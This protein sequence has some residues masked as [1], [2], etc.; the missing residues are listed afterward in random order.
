MNAAV[1]VRS[2]TTVGQLR[3]AKARFDAAQAEVDRVLAAKPTPPD[4][5][6]VSAAL[7]DARRDF[8]DASAARALGTATEAELRNA[9]AA[10][11][12]ARKAH[13]AAAVKAEQFAMLE[14]GFARALAQAQAEVDAAAEARRE[15][16][17]EWLRAE[18]VAT[19]RAY[20]E[21]ADRLY[22]AWRRA[23]AIT[24]ASKARRG[25]WN[26]YTAMAAPPTIAP[27]GVWRDVKTHQGEMYR[28]QRID[29]RNGVET[30]LQLASMSSPEA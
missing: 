18:L 28:A 12:K 20:C 14:A 4:P 22:A 6:V 26:G 15:A 21:A 24:N 11:E 8:E 3:A 19:D 23:K 17:V 7:E 30:A 16:E 29:D 2:E 9:A 13:E 10:L 5:S 25:G 1:P 27:L